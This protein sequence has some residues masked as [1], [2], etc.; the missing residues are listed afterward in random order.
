MRREEKNSPSVD[1]ILGIM[2]QLLC[3]NTAIEDPF[4]V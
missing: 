1:P 3:S 4:P 2:P